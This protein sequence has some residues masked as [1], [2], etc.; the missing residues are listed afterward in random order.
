MNVVAFAFV[1]QNWE[2]ALADEM[3]KAV[4]R[5]DIAGRKAGQAGRVQIQHLAVG[6]N[7]LSVLVDEEYKLGIGV[8]AQAS[9]HLFELLVLLFI[10][11]DGSRHRFSSMKAG[12]KTSYKTAY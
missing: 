3:R 8:R 9:Y 7:L 4:G 10:Q 5:R 11:Y 2:A 6:G 12:Q 1:R